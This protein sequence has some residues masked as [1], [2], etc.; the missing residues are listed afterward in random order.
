MRGYPLLA[1][2]DRSVGY[3]VAFDAAVG[4]FIHINRQNLFYHRVIGPR[5]GI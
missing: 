5:G 3:S 4:F 2:P 1:D